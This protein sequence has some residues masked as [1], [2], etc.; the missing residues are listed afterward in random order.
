METYL[1][2]AFRRSEGYGASGFPAWGIP[3]GGTLATQK[4]I[5][6]LRDWGSDLPGGLGFRD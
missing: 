2:D 3:P 1:S 6:C 4:D 5:L